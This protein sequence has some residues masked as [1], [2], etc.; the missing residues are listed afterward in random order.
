MPFL[1]RNGCG[2]TL[3][4]LYTFFFYLFIPAIILRLFWRGFRAPA[5]WRRWPERFGFYPPLSVQQCL[6]IH[7]VSLGEVQAAIP[8]I[9]RLQSQYTTF[10]LLVTTMTP[11]GADRITALFGDQVTHVYLPYDLPGAVKRFLNHMRPRLAIIMETELWPNLFHACTQH[12]VPILL[13]N[14][15]LSVQSTKRYQY[16]GSLMQQVLSSVST[17]AAQT[18]LDAQ[19]FMTLGAM[20]TQIQVTGNIKF[21]MELSAHWHTQAAALRRSWGKKRRV[22]IAASTHAGE[23]D[24]VLTALASVKQHIKDFLL[25]LVPR[26]PERF[27]AVAALC[28]KQ[29]YTLARR[30]RGEP[31]EA[32]TDIY[33]GD[34]LGEL[35]VLYG[36]CDVAFVGG[37]LVAVGGHNLLEPAMAGLPIITGPYVFECAEISRQ[38][39]ALQAAQ[40]IHNA[41]QLA[42]KLLVYLKD[43]TL[44][45]QT[46][47]RARLFAQRNRGALQR[48]WPLIERYIQN[49]TTIINLNAI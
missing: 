45:H 49:E 31:C 39:V 32:T 11:T 37:S 42:A 3:R 29:G 46:G 15:R 9:K 2:Q 12:A 43:E 33:L 25:V 34:T 23:E 30:S 14:A 6:W 1:K 20:P 35:A 41:T 36:A 18:E 40:H 7:A 21:D 47:E 38:L 5:Y 8:L 17:I 16:V 27:N 19:H 24:V 13:A 4:K 28:L 10:P 48:L 26:H 22:W 44:R